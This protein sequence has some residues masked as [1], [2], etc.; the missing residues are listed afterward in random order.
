MS[1]T[2]TITN[3]PTEAIYKHLDF[4]WRTALEVFKRFVEQHHAASDI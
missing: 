2:L 4:Y 3:F 1:L